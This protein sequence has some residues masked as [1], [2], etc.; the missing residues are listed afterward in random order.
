MSE[1]LG[2]DSRAEFLPFVS[3]KSQTPAKIVV[4]EY[5]TEYP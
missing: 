2:D 5:W 1:G 4:L 3:Q